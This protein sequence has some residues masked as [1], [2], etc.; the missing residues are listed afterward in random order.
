MSKFV[1]VVA[2]LL[3][4]GAVAG[5]F[6][7]KD[8][9]TKTFNLQFGL[10][11][12]GLT[13]GSVG[14]SFLASKEQQH[15]T[16][17]LSEK[18]DKEM[19]ILIKEKDELLSHNKEF[20]VI[21]NE[22]DKT[23]SELNERLQR[24]EVTVS[25]LKQSNQV[26]ELAT[27]QKIAEID[28]KLA[29][30]DDRQ[31]LFIEEVKSQFAESLKIKIDYEYERIGDT[32]V[33]RLNDE[34]FV[35]IHSVLNRFYQ[36]LKENH[37]RHYELL[38][39]I[40]SLEGTDIVDEL[41]SIYF[42][43]SGEISSYHVRLRN[44]LNLEERTTLEVFRDELIERR[45][46]KKF[47]ARE[48]VQ[49]GLDYLQDKSKA[50]L[51]KV[52]QT[53]DQND[54]ELQQIRENVTDLIDQIEARNLEINNLKE[55]IAN[56]KSPM[57]WNLANSRELE[58]GNLIIKYF[59]KNGKGIYLDRSHIESD[60]YA[61]ILYYQTD[62]NPRAIIEKELNEHSEPLQQFCRVIKPIEFSF[63]QVLRD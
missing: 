16:K 21:Y 44:I 10:I 26:L 63:I 12:A 41:T 47:V 60:G 23:I 9:N 61:L 33:F 59:W 28:A 36:F 17:S 31:D 4:F 56:L 11:T 35:E 51:E 40:Y 25:A 54:I 29:R 55:Q 5:Y 2:G 15:K 3:T 39:D 8:E 13:V 7:G 20:T 50:G 42:Q 49:Q 19:K 38:T 46:P 52:R 48:K 6:N 34:R 57:F 45:D 32:T 27:K 37:H 53:A 14:S 1:S 18:F 43:V 24:K 30:D 22:K 62:R 58:I